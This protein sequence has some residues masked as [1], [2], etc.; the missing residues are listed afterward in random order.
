VRFDER[1]LRLMRA[2][3]QVRGAALARQ[4]KPGELRAALALAKA[5]QKLRYAAAGPSLVFEEP[6]LRMLLEAVRFAHDEV[7]WAGSQR[8]AAGDGRIQ[9]ILN[10]FP[11][12]VE[13]GLWRSF[14][15]TRE[16]DELA[17]RLD[18]ALR[19]M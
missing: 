4:A 2:A 18:A 19:S 5:G 6:E 10:A 3:E 8:D 17:Q 1:E 16:L 7:Q 9:A 13:R 14:G 12:L 11:E 15:L